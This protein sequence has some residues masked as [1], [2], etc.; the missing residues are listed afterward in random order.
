LFGE[1][2]P[3]TKNDLVPKI[4]MHSDSI[5][6]V[7]QQT[8]LQSKTVRDNILFYK[9]MDEEKY[10]D[11]IKYACLETDL[12]EMEGGDMCMLSDKGNNLSGGQRVRLSMARAIYA[13][14]EIVM[15]DDPIS[16]LDVH[17]GKE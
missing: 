3:Y 9:D 11:A 17:V 10:W 14:K 5:A 7:S 1:L 8:W 6:Y 16:A 13:D 2:N 12:A 15:L 4:T